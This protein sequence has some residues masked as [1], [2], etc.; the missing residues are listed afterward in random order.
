MANIGIVGSG[1]V[2]AN[3]AF[4]IAERNI[5]N[6]LM[7]DIQDGLAKGKALDMMEAAPVRGYQYGISG[8]DTLEETKSAEAVVVTAGAVRKPGMKREDLFNE[9]I[10]IIDQIAAEYT[11]YNGVI[12]VGTEPVDL[13]T[14][15]FVQ[16]SG[17]P[18]N[19]V[20][21]LGGVLDSTRLR[22]FI[23]RETGI[24][25]ENITAL[26]IGRHSPQMLA[27]PNY[28]RVNGVPATHLMSENRFE[29]VVEETRRAGDLIVDMAQ[30][31]SSYYGP[32]AAAAD[33][34]QAIAWDTKRI[35]SVSTV[36]S[37]Q[38]GISDVAMS[39][40]AVL[41][42]RGIE[43]ILEPNLNQEQLAVLT[44]SAKELQRVMESV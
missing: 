18:A 44:D 35:L 40:P 27:L 39:L 26:V 10:G 30:R 13:M 14:A 33:V 6:V 21:G 8:V 36:W 4:F 20:I 7:Y 19:R 2:G 1:N 9:N 37:G 11:E 42:A 38:F 41:G 22:Y 43:R 29:R 34:V 28:C 16:T 3:T 32:S 5:G 24:T 31:A 25:T 15:R 17:L 23:G 12:V